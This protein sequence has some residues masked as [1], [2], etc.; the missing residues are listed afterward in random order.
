M[1]TSDIRWI[2]PGHHL[3]AGTQPGIHEV[4]AFFDQ[5]G[6]GNF[7]AEPLVVVENGHYVID[8][9]C[10]WTEKAGSLDLT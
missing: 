2:I 1:T 9:H 4:L 6:K 10:G 8:H 5:L 7:K 3:R